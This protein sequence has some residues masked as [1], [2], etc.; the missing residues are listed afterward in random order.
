MMSTI[1]Q[2]DDSTNFNYFQVQK[3]TVKA[4]VP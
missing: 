1:P 4:R 3:N 2:I